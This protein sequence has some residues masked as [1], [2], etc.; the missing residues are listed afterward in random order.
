MNIY[1]KGNLVLTKDIEFKQLYFVSK[2]V[3]G[4]LD[5]EEKIESIKFVRKTRSQFSNHD[6][7]KL[8]KYLS[9]SCPIPDHGRNK[10]IEV[11][12]E[13]IMNVLCKLPIVKLGFF[14]RN[15]EIIYEQLIDKYG[16]L[17]AKEIKNGYIFPL[18]QGNDL[19]YEFK[20]YRTDNIL[21]GFI[22]CDLKYR[23][24]E[25]VS[26]CGCYCIGN[27]VA[28][29]NEKNNYTIKNKS[30]QVIKLFQMNAL[31]VV[32]ISNSL[33]QLSNELNTNSSSTSINDS[34]LAKPTEQNFSPYIIPS[35]NFN[36][37]K[38][39]R[40][41]REILNGL[42]D[43]DIA[44]LRDMTRNN[45]SDISIGEFKQ[46]SREEKLKLLDSMAEQKNQD[47]NRLKVSLEKRKV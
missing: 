38:S 44:L 29:V 5:N 19:N 1:Y 11:Y 4:I 6:C 32:S 17:Y 14:N 31:D 33:Q 41:V 13:E 20:V 25:N 18:L 16:N 9:K 7:I 39:L 46:M 24:R 37:L 26:L 47:N 21:E 3:G 22:D 45:L 23:D 10:R 34:N 42:S 30:K 2:I 12:S 36:K 15:Y 8:V 27:G 40:E 35:N 28:N 43:E